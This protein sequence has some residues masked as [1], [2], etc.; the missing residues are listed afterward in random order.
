MLAHL[1]VL[2][3]ILPLIAAPVCILLRRATLVWLFATVV[4]VLTFAIS[5]VLLV[6]VMGGEPIRYELGNWVAPWGIVYVVDSVSALILV[7][8]SGIAAVAMPFALRSAASEI[9]PD[10]LYLFYTMYLLCLAGLL[11]IAITGDAFNL[12]VFLEISSLSSYTLISLGRNRKALHAAFQYLVMGTIGATLYLIGIGLLYALTGTLNMADLAVRL[13]PLLD[14]RITL[15]AFGFIVVGLGLKLAMFPLH[16]W[17]PNA[18]THS[19]SVVSVFLAGTATKVSLYALLRILY[20][21]FGVRFDFEQQPMSALFAI[22][23]VAGLVICSLVAMYQQNVKRILAFS[24]VAQIGYMLLGVAFA[25]AAGLQ[26]SL[27]HIFNHALLKSGLFLAVGCLVLRTGSSQLANLSGIAREM[28]WTMAAFVVC[29]LSLIGVPATAG[30]ISKWYLVSAAIEKGWW[31]FAA[32]I[33]ATSLLAVIYIWRV[34]EVAYFRPA[35]DRPAGSPPATEAP[36]SMLVP[37]WIIA[38]A[39]IWFG[40]DASAP[41]AITARAAKALMGAGG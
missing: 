3:V 30:F 16:L 14:S 7:I 22:V 6:Q 12:F 23:A 15:A 35:S 33:V 19:P 21:V 40:L 32:L 9:E 2:Q 31:P 37:T 11:G 34:I 10:R 13:A 26:A 25:T 17:L 38:A 36:L 20:D 39:N 8:V 28:P 24:S 27:L 1:P 29:G 4:C 41:A 5:V 18:Y